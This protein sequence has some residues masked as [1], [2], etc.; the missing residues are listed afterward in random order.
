MHLLFNGAYS[1]R[2][3]PELPS[4]K[5]ESRLLLEWKNPTSSPIYGHLMYHR[6]ITHHLGLR[7]CQL[8]NN[9][10]AVDNGPVQEVN[11]PCSESENLSASVTMQWSNLSVLV[12]I[13]CNMQYT[14]LTAIT[15][16]RWLFLEL[17]YHLVWLDSIFFPKWPHS[18]KFWPA[19]I[20][21]YTFLLLDALCLQ[22]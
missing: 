7:G 18:S 22:N 20:S 16:V 3:M 4:S 9:G 19:N 10:S 15:K 14:Q 5:R 11:Q 1:D 13:T 12:S 21:Y 17:A 2:G 6:T 8:I